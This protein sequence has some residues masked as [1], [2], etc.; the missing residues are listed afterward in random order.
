MRIFRGLLVLVAAA[1]TFYSLNV[2]AVQNGYRDRLDFKNRHY[3]DD[4][5]SNRHYR[6]HSFNHHNN[7]MQDSIAPDSTRNSNNTPL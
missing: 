2:F 6:Q 4:D 1:A 7:K 3:H 5:C